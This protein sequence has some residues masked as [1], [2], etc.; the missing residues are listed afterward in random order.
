[1]TPAS[2]A[3]TNSISARSPSGANAGASLNNLPRD[4]NALSRE[5]D[6]SGATGESK[7]LIVNYIPTPVTDAEL[8]QLFEQFG[9]LESARVIVDRHTLHPKGYGFVKFR[10]EEDAQKAMLQMNGFEIHNKRLKVT[11]AMGPQNTAINNMTTRMEAL[12]VASPGNPLAPASHPVQQV[13]QV[14]QVQPVQQVPQVLQYQQLPQM[15]QMQG[16]PQMQGLQYTM[17]AAGNGGYG[18]MQQPQQ[19]QPHQQQPQQQQQQSQGPMQMQL[20]MS[21]PA[22]QPPGQGPW[23]ATMQP[24]GQQ[25][26]HQGQALPPGTITQ[27]VVVDA[28]MNPVNMFQAPAAAMPAIPGGSAM[29]PPVFGQNGLPMF[30]PFRPLSPSSDPMFRDS[31]QFS[32]AS[33]YSPQSNS[34]S[35]GAP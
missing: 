11:P 25:Q 2:S 32:L 26:F 4:N 9:T 19:Q 17:Q 15:T 33:S 18:M 27:Y 3:S 23:Q 12:Q 20:V 21:Q 6:S 34:M 5:L 30:A 13:Q 28:N 29:P 16:L 7:N 24:Q 8:R 35:W 31:C 22:G 1:M 10:R 14:Q